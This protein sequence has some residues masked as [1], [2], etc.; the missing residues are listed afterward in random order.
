VLQEA[1]IKV[2]IFGIN[3]D[4]IDAFTFKFLGEAFFKI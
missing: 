3:S 1:L 4:Q 2:I